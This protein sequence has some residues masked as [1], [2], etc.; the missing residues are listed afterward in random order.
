M[1]ETNMNDSDLTPPQQKDLLPKLLK[2][3]EYLTINMLVLPLGVTMLKES[4]EVDPETYYSMKR[5]LRELL[6][7][8]DKFKAD[9]T[10][11]FDELP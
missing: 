11:A 3:V 6:V 9:L 4:R 10:K 7:T 8:A 1:E 2:V 5:Q